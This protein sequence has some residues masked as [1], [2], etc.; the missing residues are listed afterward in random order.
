MAK[1]RDQVERAIR[2]YVATLESLGIPVEQVVLFGSH[3]HGAARDESDIDLAVFSNVFGGEEHLEFSGILSQAKWTSDT[4]IEAI[5]FHTNSLQTINPASFLAEI[6]R[7]GQVVYRRPA[8]SPRP[9][10]AG[11]P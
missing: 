4:S 6:L 9:L 2:R 5:G 10:L 11:A 3:A 8:D 1:T 7:T